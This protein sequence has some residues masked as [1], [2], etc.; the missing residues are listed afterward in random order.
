MVENSLRSRFHTRWM[1]VALLSTACLLT[2]THIPNDA[3]P[4]VLQRNL[5]DKVEHAVAYGLIAILF[6]CSLRRPVR[7]LL[8]LI[9][10][11]VLA[12]IGALDEI[13]QPLVNRYAS[14]ADY[15]SDL[16][17]IAGACVIFL[18]RRGP[19]GNAKVKMQDAK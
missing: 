4:K 17:G 19:S 1:A 7:P 14:F 6:L 10:L 13:T 12:V 11:A 18:V 2:L 5:L 15:A 8:V 16:V 9:V 3:L